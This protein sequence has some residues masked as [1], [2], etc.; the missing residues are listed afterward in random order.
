MIPG[1]Y[2]TLAQGRAF[3]VPGGER[4]KPILVAMYYSTL[5]TMLGV[6]VSIRK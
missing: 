1:F 4:G 5:V 6:G 2:S 3:G